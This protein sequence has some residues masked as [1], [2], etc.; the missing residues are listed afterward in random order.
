MSVTRQPWAQLRPS[1]GEPFWY[2]F[3]NPPLNVRKFFPK[4]S[5][6]RGERQEEYIVAEGARTLRRLLARP[7]APFGG[8]GDS[9]NGEKEGIVHASRGDPAARRFPPAAGGCL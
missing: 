5:R 6:T 1:R 9:G 4:L 2:G 7:G 8:F 3:C